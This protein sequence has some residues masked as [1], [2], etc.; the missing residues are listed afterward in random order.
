MTDEIWKKYE[1][2]KSLKGPAFDFEIWHKSRFSSAKTQTIFAH[3]CFNQ[4]TTKMPFLNK[5]VFL[6]GLSQAIYKIRFF[7]GPNHK[8]VST[9]PLFRSTNRQRL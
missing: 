3:N 7:F 8:V 6:I 5:F 9:A 1:I 4:K 2:A